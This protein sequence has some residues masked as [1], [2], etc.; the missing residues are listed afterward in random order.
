MLALSETYGDLDGENNYH[1]ATVFAQVYQSL[2]ADQ[3]ARLVELRHSIMSGTYDDGTPFDFTVCSTPFLYSAVITDPSVL[4][5]Y[6][7]D[8]DYL[9]IEP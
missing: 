3:L 6:I 8:T 4:T 5:P 1:Y 2:T 7:A 9:F